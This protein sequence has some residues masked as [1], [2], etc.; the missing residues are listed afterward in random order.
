MF[1]EGV[2]ILTV[3][4]LGGSF[5]DGIAHAFNLSIDPRM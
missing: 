5:F 3:I 2:G 4:T 1:V